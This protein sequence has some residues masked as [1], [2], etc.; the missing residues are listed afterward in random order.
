MQLRSLFLALILAGSACGQATFVP[1][2]IVGASGANVDV[3]SGSALIQDS[4]GTPASGSAGLFYINQAAVFSN[5]ITAPVTSAAGQSA[6]SA[7]NN[8]VYLSLNGGTPTVI[9][10]SSGIIQTVS[11]KSANFTV[12]TADKGVLFDV[13]TGASNIT[14]TLPAAATAGNGWYCFIRKADTAAGLV[15]TSPTTSPAAVSAQVQN[16]L[17]LLW[18]DG[19]SWYNKVHLGNVDAS[20]AVTIAAGGSNQNINLTP[21]GTGYVKSGDWT[22]GSGETRIIS[23]KIDLL[24][25]YGRYVALTSSTANAITFASGFRVS[26]YSGADLNGGGSIDAAIQ[27]NGAGTLEINNGTGGTYRDLK[28][29]QLNPDSTITASGTT[30]NATIN[31]GAGTI[32]FAAAGTTTITVTNSLVTTS[33]QVIL[34]RQKNDA[35][36]T[37]LAVNNKVSGAFDIVI[38]VAATAELPVYFELRN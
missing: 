18:S 30:G 29:R 9:G 21:S 13:T 7:F 37:T 11:A 6:L 14:A 28:L 31:K 27:R 15:L 8:Q 34:T 12:T 3:S 22:S 24:A 32:N 1:S 26:F 2:K 19:T 20:G 4:T 35:T 16:A 38:N 17:V 23:G 36:A 5:N 10:G 33:T 25:N